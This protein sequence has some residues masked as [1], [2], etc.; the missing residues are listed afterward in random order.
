METTTQ[1]SG[2]VAILH[3]E[4]RMTAGQD[5]ASLSDRIKCMTAQG[6]RAFLLDFQQ[7]SYADS[8]CLGDIVE[9]LNRV[10]R[11]GGS[12]RLVNV[13]TRVRRLLDLSHLND[14]LQGPTVDSMETAL[15]G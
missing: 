7:V 6:V 14:V 1:R 8:T 12:L 9:A 13:P 10:R 2:N 3:L 4:G 5:Q 15:A 11:H